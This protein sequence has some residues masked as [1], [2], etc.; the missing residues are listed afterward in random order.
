M[1]VYVPPV[2]FCSE[3]MIALT[4]GWKGVDIQRFRS[5]GRRFLASDVKL[6][7]APCEWL[8]IRLWP[9]KK[10]PERGLAVAGTADVREIGDAGFTWMGRDLERYTRIP[11]HIHSRVCCAY[12]WFALGEKNR[13]KPVITIL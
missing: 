11:N 12:V 4:L 1:I 3:R 13:T 9:R 8:V 6:V 10:P 7:A 5:N 2:H